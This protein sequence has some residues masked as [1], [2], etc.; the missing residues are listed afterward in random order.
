MWKNKL[1]EIIQEKFLYGEQTNNGATKEEIDFLLKEIKSE[2]K[3][4]LPDDY[5]Q[6]LKH[7][8]GLEF[9]GF[10]LYGIDQYLLNI[11]SNQN[12]NGLIENNKIW[13]K[14]DWQKK[15]I[16]IGE[17]NFSWYV[18][19]LIEYIYCELDKP[20]GSKIEMFNNIDILIEKIL[21]NALM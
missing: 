2:F 12:I 18:Y 21:N 15:Y 9:N 16:F 14:N 3:I 10:V 13:Y 8:N 7:I 5:I 4:Y 20:S 17:S 11:E 6:I 19:D 1:Q